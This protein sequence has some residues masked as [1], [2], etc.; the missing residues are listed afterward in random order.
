MSKTIRELV[1][2]HAA[3]PIDQGQLLDCIRDDVREEL[4][5]MLNRGEI[6][7]DIN[8]KVRVPRP[9]EEP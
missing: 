5:R 4:R 1:E 6:R 3:D 9:K 7:L 8:W 2:K